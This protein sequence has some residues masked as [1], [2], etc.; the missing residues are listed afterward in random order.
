MLLMHSDQLFISCFKSPAPLILSLSS[1][2]QG[3]FWDSNNLSET[4]S[5]SLATLFPITG[6]I[7]DAVNPLPSVISNHMMKLA[8]AKMT[9]LIKQPTHVS[10]CNL[11]TSCWKCIIWMI[12]PPPRSAAFLDT[13]WEHKLKHTQWGI[14]AFSIPLICSDAKILTTLL[15]N[16]FGVQKTILALDQLAVNKWILS[17]AGILINNFSTV[18]ALQ[19]LLE[20]TLNRELHETEAWNTCTT[21]YLRNLSFR[22]AVL[23][24]TLAA[25]H[26]QILCKTDTIVNHFSTNFLRYW[27][28]SHMQ[29]KH[30]IYLQQN[31]LVNYINN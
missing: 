20:R 25:V 10:I 24:E 5:H 4:A 6:N 29:W 21:N 18:L 2:D 15:Y 27:I 12:P 28:N 19:I 7:C 16:F 23:S 31:I 8:H 26:K 30:F 3:R 22:M 11:P 13:S 14:L 9:C 17:Y 1:W